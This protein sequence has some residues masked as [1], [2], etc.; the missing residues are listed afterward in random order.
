MKKDDINSLFINPTPKIGYGLYAIRKSLKMAVDELKSHISGEVLDL[1][2][3]IMPYKNYLRSNGQISNYTGID[4]ENSDYHNKVKPDL[5]WDGITIPLGDESMDWVIATE[6]MEHY[7]DTQHILLEIKRVLK[8]GG[9]LFFTVPFIYMLHES[10]Y[11][12]HRFTPFS[13]E[14]HFKK[15]HYGN[16]NIYALGGFNYSLVIMMSL[17]S[18]KSGERGLIRL[19]IKCFLFFFH[20]SLLNRNSQLNSG[21]KNFNLFR[22]HDMPSG[23]WGNAQK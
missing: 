8:P 6:F 20:K 15:A 18:K 4:L 7:F 22:N 5:Y 19:L 16:I 1:G 3:G 17:W 13:I 2:C 23:L 9:R 11:D 14:S 21:K 12:Y 10:P